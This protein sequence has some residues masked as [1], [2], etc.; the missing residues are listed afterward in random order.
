[1]A[2]INQNGLPLVRVAIAFVTRE[3]LEVNV[4]DQMG[5]E[6]I[7]TTAIMIAIDPRNEG[8]KRQSS[9]RTK[10]GHLQE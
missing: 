9:S 6:A 10:E 3:E 2:P 5:L 7:R 8:R 1:M 4:S